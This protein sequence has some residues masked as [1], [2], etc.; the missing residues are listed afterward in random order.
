M[1]I[2]QL[3]WDVTLGQCVDAWHGPGS[4]SWL[5]APVLGRSGFLSLLETHLGLT[6]PPVH[7]AVRVTAYLTALRRADGPARFFHGSLEADSIETAARLLAWRDEWRMGGWDGQAGLGWPHRLRDLAEVEALAGALPPG[8]AERLRAVCIRLEQR[9][10]PIR[11]VRLLEPMAA[12]PALWQELLRIVKAT[13]PTGLVPSASGDL[14]RLQAACIATLERG[15][16][17]ASATLAGDGTVQVRRAMSRETAEHWLAAHCRANPGDA[18]MVVSD[19]MGPSLDDTLRAQ[20]LP[21]GGFNARS[22]LRPGL[23]ALAL[24]LE[25]LWDP[26]DPQRLL[27]FLLHPISPMRSR[28][29]RHALARAIAERP[30]VGGKAWESA[31]LSVIKYMPERADDIRADVAYWMPARRWT[32]LEGIPLEAVLERVERFR[33]RC[34][35]RVGIAAADDSGVTPAAWRATLGPCEAVAEAVRILQRAGTPVLGPRALQQLLAQSGGNA[36]NPIAL[37]QV[38]CSTIATSPAACAVERADEVVWWM[39]EAAA[40]P[41][42]HPWTGN[43]LAALAAAGVKLRDPALEMKRLVSLWLLPALAARHRLVIM[44]PPEGSEEHP[45]WQLVRASVQGL[46]VTALETELAAQRLGEALPHRPLPAPAGMWKLPAAATW[47]KAFPAPS[48][49]P[50]QSFSSLDP[51]FRHPALAILRDAASLETGSVLTAGL[52]KRLLGNLGHSLAEQLFLQEGALGWGRERLDKWFPEAL[53]TLLRAE[54]L[55]LLAPGRAMQLEQFRRTAHH[56]LAALLRM[57]QE[58]GALSVSTE[59]SLEGGLGGLG[60]RGT[61]D[62]YV[63][64]PQGSA[65]LDLKWKRAQTFQ[66]RLRQ[67]DF[68]QLALYHRLLSE[69]NAPLPIALGYFTFEDATLSTTSPDVFPGARV[70]QPRDGL[71]ASAL[72][73]MA[74][75]TWEWRV[76]Q[77]E[78]GEIEVVHDIRQASPMPDGCLPRRDL[79]YLER[80]YAA[81][82][83]VTD[84]G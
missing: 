23:Q 58:A 83:G 72:L 82:L 7:A 53:A 17:P 12:W 42:P 78:A 20:G 50:R 66:D 65:A 57:L 27:D 75:A 28:R 74:A 6:A 10:I 15:S 55:P 9:R 84:A 81:L 25:P 76:R 11:S 54:G 77:W 41:R 39:P 16:V 61:V 31:L 70:I 14:G 8:E 71:N 40:L 29:V 46:A 2:E 56:A 67:G 63:K 1:P 18:R 59:R 34:A 35:E 19:E 79:P 22:P 38:G 60:L 73:T 26:V 45:A 52:D 68:L 37:A 44:L 5:A 62:L 64:L 48:R 43:E 51:L 4:R 36:P 80:S 24:A 33:Q 3:A 47:R 30:G 49:R 69:D 32:R 21:T 13:D